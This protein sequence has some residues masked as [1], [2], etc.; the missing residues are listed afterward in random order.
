MNFLIAFIAASV[1]LLIASYGALVSEDCGRMAVFMEGVITF[2][3]FLTYSLCVFTGNIIIAVILCAAITVS[4][5]TILSIIIEKIQL[6]PFIASLAMNLFFNAIVSFLS[7]KFFATRG[8]L[9]DSAFSFNPVSSRIWTTVAGFA[10]VIIAY[11]FLNCTKAGLYFKITGKDQK[12]LKARSI[13]V[14]FY[15]IA[16]WSIAALCASLAGSILAIRLS[17]FVP[18]LASGLGWISLAIVFLG[19]KKSSVVTGGSFVLALAQTASANI[20]NI[21]G[22]ENFPSAVLIGLPYLAALV[23][24]L[25][26]PKKD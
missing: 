18:G 22:L 1:P 5:I 2:A 7:V 23:F 3:G 20:Q 19:K 26:Y 13:N 24:I 9:T 15:R 25:L 14:L 4:V 8:V 10:F 21:R 11:I 16:S 12:V 17:S 6:N